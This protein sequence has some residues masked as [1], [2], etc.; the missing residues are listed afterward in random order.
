MQHRALEAEL[1]DGA[2]ELVGGGLGVHGRQ[3]RKGREAFRVGGADLGET[4]VHLARQVGCDIGAELLGRGRAVRQHLDVDAGLVH[5]LEP[6]A[7]KVEKP[8][9]G[10]V[11]PARLRPGEMLGKFRVPIVFFDGDDRAARLLHHDVSP[12]CFFRN[13]FL[14]TGIPPVT[15]HHDSR[16]TVP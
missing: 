4:V 7:A 9:V 16:M 3:R 14:A 6:Q 1:G 15:G 11:A 13:R 5:F 12:R 2:F 10:L 8:L